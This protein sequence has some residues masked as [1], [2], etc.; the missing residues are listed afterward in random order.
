[1]GAA[2]NYVD[3]TDYFAGWK[4]VLNARNAYVQYND[5]GLWNDRTNIGLGTSPQWKRQTTG[6]SG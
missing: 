3:T 2:I 6:E 1:M 4:T 5:V